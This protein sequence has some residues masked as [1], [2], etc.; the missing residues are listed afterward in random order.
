VIRKENASESIL[1]M[2]MWAVGTVLTT[3]LWLEI[4]EYKSIAFGEWHIAHVLFGGILM[5]AAILTTI[6]W[7]G[8][9]AQQMAIILSGIG[10]GWFVDEIG[11]F[12][13]RDNDYFF[14]PAIIFIYVSFILLFLLYRR[15]AKGEKDKGIGLKII[16]L[17]TKIVDVTYTKMLKKKLTLILLGLY[18]I[19]FSIDK[20][21]DAVRILAS[22]EKMAVITRFYRDYDFFSRTDTYMIG[23]MLGFDLLMAIIFLTGWYW[24]AKRKRMRAIEYFQYGLLV[25]IL[26]GSI[27]K[28]YFEQFSAV[29]GLA[30]NIVIWR[31]LGELRT[32]GSS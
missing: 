27:F 21:W 10:W 24:M 23:F 13:T 15:L 16:K 22:G 4:N 19:Y 14:R 31:L 1:Q 17:A 18:S 32:K 6:V 8:V 29:F 11:K 9:K 25:N 7:E 28:F 30:V 5:L 26:L 3:R 12:I 20:L 2:L